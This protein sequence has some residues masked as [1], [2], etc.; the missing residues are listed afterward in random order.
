LRHSTLLFLFRCR[1]TVFLFLSLFTALA[2][3]LYTIPIASTQRTHHVHSSCVLRPQWQSY[4]KSAQKIMKNTVTLLKGDVP[5]DIEAIVYRLFRTRPLDAR[6]VSIIGIAGPSIAARCSSSVQSHSKR[7]CPGFSPRRKEQN[8]RRS[9]LRRSDL[10]VII[11][12][13]RMT[14]SCADCQLARVDQT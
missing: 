11:W 7:D 2:A 9:R 13:V 14:I 3:T 5:P 12:K 6:W 10:C 1:R 8:L 4:S